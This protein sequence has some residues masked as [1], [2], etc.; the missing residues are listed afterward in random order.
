LFSVCPFDAVKMVVDGTPIPRAEIPIIKEK[1]IPE[2]TS[3]KIGKV[4]LADP[5]FKSA[6]WDKLL[7]K[8][9]IKKKVNS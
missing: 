6:F 7:D 8:I 9:I 5:N 1:I 3:L 4:E 2:F